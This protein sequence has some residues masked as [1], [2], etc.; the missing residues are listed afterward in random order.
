MID[1]V[2]IDVRVAIVAEAAVAVG[3]AYEYSPVAAV[4]LYAVIGATLVVWAMGET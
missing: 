3:A 2:P 4:I 1:A